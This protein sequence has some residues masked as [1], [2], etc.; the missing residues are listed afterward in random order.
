[1]T[2]SS[3]TASLVPLAP[4]TEDSDHPMIRKKKPRQRKPRE[5][6][7]CLWFLPTPVLN[8]REDYGGGRSGKR[9][10]F[11]AYNRLS[12]KGCKKTFHK[13]IGRDTQI[14]STTT[15]S[16]QSSYSY[17]APSKARQPARSSSV[18][19]VRKS[20]RVSSRPNKYF[21]DEI[22]IIGDTEM[23]RKRNKKIDQNF[24]K[25]NLKAQRAVVESYNN[26]IQ[27]EEEEEEFVSSKR[28]SKRNK[29]R[30]GK[31]V[32]KESDDDDIEVLEIIM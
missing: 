31:H 19:M 15:T 8:R 32:T 24:A 25:M 12:C 28:T 22:Q 11:T 4:L 20:S 6:W 3:T 14:C 9:E 30:K 26:S 10:G 27:Y 18:R 2:T 21:D 7:N 29:G 1:M 13:T 16:R 17:R 23:E 5:K